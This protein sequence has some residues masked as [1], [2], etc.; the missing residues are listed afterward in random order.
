MPRQE[1]GLEEALHKQYP[2]QVI[3]ETSGGWSIVFPDAP[4]AGAYAESWDEIGPKAHEGLMLWLTV[5]AELGRALPEPTKGGEILYS[6]T[7]QARLDAESAPFDPATQELFSVRDI[8]ALA[9]ISS[10]R[11]RQIALAKH[12]G[13]LIGGALIF[14][15]EDLAAFMHRRSAGRPPKV[16][17]SA[18]AD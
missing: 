11:V 4:G 12:I 10:G 2:F 5:T 8:A 13:Q 7:G 15:H 18:V 6:A 9:G 16:T 17:T 14:T 1:V 3:A